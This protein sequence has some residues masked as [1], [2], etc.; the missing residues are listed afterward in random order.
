M[1][2]AALLALRD[3][4]DDVRGAAADAL[5][6]MVDALAEASAAESGPASVVKKEDDDDVR[7]GDPDRSS[8]NAIQCY[9]WN[10]GC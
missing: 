7:I 6:P 10:F 2:P 1:L 3:K 4:D 5:L 9:F 8:T